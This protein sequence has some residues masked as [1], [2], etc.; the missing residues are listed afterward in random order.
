MNH[1]DE[2]QVV[3]HTADKNRFVTDALLATESIRE[4]MVRQGR[5]KEMA[6]EIE[7]TVQDVIAW[8]EQVGGVSEVYF[9]HTGF[10][11]IFCIVS[12]DED[13]NLELAERVTELDLR[14]ASRTTTPFDFIVF[15]ASEADGAVA[16]CGI[17]D[18]TRAILRV[19][20]P[21]AT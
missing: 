6:Q 10:S 16:F 14:T 20:S 5:I 3:V 15:R 11:F 2:R 12:K 13:P 9:G 7:D 21:A 4:S 1:D 17:D 8:V 19:E 18:R